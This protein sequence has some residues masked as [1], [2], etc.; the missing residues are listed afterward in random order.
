MDNKKIATE[1]M[2]PCPHGKFQKMD[3]PVCTMEFIEAHKGQF[4]GE[5]HKA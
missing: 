2:K 4:A 1:A 5:E 3:C